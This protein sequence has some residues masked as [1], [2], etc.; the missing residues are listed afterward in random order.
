MTDPVQLI[1]LAEIDATALTRDRTGLDPEPQAELELSIAASGL[2]QPIELFPL[3]PPSAP[4]LYGLLTG[5]RRLHAFRTLHERTGQDRYA[6][7][8]AFLRAET[9]LAAAFAAMVEENEIRADLSPFERGLICVTARNQGAFASI[10]EAVDRLYPNA[11]KVK[12]LRLRTLAFFAEEM[13]GQLT[14]P[15]RLSQARAF[16]ISR[17]L[18]AGFGDLI[19]T[20][21]EESSLKDPDHQWDLLQPILAEA[22]EH[23]RKP[24]TS[25]RPGRPRRV[26]RPRYALTVRRER[27]RDGWSLHFTGREA[28][29]PLMDLVLDEV[30]R[31]Y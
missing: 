6:A 30:E 7:I 25:P 26:L 29:G 8:P 19:R 31:M 23:T 24:E 1:L 16:R 2:R 20:A 4:H 18:S 27:T 14:A 13:D 15:E 28:T 17:A 12:R 3:S 21:L 10:E 5:Y 9:T 22:D 11:C